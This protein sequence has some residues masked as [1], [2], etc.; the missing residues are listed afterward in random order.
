MTSE[1]NSVHA[2]S[3]GKPYPVSQT[4][5]SSSPGDCCNGIVPGMLLARLQRSNRCVQSG[6]TD[7]VSEQQPQEHLRAFETVT[8]GGGGGV[9]SCG[10]QR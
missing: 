5:G 10:Q 4:L 7:C 3:K 6:A 1:E 8:A 2:K 9:R